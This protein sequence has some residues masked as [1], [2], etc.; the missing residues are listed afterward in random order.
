M[1]VNNRGVR[2]PSSVAVADGGDFKLEIGTPKRVVQKHAGK[3]FSRK[4]YK[5][6]VILRVIPRVILRMIQK[7]ISKCDTTRC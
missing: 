2:V 7:V 4:Q 1:I 5:E 3:F 6:R